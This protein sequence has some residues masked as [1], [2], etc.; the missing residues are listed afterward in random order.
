MCRLFGFRSVVVSKVQ[1]SLV[2]ASN[3]LN[4]QGQIHADGW[5]L[6]YYAE[7]HPHLIKSEKSAFEDRIFSCVSGIVSSET[8]VAHIRKATK[9]KISLT[10]THPFQYGPW[11]FA[12]NGNIHNFQT[13]CPKILEEVD[14]RLRP[15]I[16]GETDSE[17]IFYFLLTKIGKKFDLANHNIP[18]DQLVP[19]VREA[20]DS[21]LEIIGPYSEID[22]AGPE[23]TYITF[24][25]TNGKTLLAHQGGKNLL[26]STY[27]KDCLNKE[28]C[29]SFGPSCIGPSPDG[30]INHLLLMSE[31]SKGAAIWSPMKLGEIAGVDERMVLIRN[32]R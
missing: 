9:G 16:L 22:Q 5:G 3:S 20:I 30:K 8:I 19:I 32:Q 29:S 24:I 6:A 15:Y 13:L 17:L 23:A 28:T 27:K 14:P 2:E 12:H 26:L 7:G 1:Q 25:L 10:N 4:C 21:L 31:E 18:I 11:I